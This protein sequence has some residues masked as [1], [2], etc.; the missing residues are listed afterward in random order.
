MDSSLLQ[1]AMHSD[2][3]RELRSIGARAK[4]GDVLPDGA[5]FDRYQYLTPGLFM[6]FLVA[7]PLLLILY[8]AIR[9]LS[10]LEV[11]Y[12]AFDKDTGPQSASAPK[13]QQ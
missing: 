10:S 6:G 4:K 11:S 9:A 1:E 7:L 2:L 13:K 3:K 12:A 5:L 8:V